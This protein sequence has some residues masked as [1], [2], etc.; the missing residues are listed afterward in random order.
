MLPRDGAAEGMTQTFTGVARYGKL[1]RLGLLM[2]EVPANEQST[3]FK[4]LR[5]WQLPIPANMAI[6]NSPEEGCPKRRSVGQ[7]SG[8][9]KSRNQEDLSVDMRPQ[10]RGAGS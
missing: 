8:I 5:N 10:Q 2:E 9:Q 4:G 6:V 3:V 7:E 1:T